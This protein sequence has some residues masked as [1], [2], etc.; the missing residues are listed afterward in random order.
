MAEAIYGEEWNLLS[1]VQLDDSLLELLNVLAGR[2]LTDHFGVGTPYSMGL[3]TVV[4]DPPG[5]LR[6]FSHRDF[7]F[8]VDSGSIGLV[9]YEAPQ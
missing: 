4:Y 9:W 3:P 8:H 7:S 5:E 2:V 6:G 1:A